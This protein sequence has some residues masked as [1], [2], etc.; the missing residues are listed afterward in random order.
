MV[1]N[2]LRKPNSLNTLIKQRNYFS[3]YWKNSFSFFCVIKESTN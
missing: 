1:F 3:N 2:K